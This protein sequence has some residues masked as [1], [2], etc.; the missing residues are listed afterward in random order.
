MI[1]EFP[2]KLNGRITT[3]ANESIFLVTQS[4]ALSKQRLEVFHTYVVKALF[5]A[6]RTTIAICDCTLVEMQYST[7]RVY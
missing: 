3:P 4:K 2:V 6:K 1:E 5:L 7:V